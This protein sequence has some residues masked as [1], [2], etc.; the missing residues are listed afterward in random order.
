MAHTIYENFVL[1]NKM[2]DLLTTAV[3]MNAYMTADT[4][5]TENAGMKKKV[6]TYTATGNVQE[7]GM[8]EG[9]TEDIEVSFIT[10]EYEVGTTQGRT[11][12]YDEQEMTDPY[13]IDVALKGLADIMTND[14]TAKAIAEFK[15]ATMVQYGATWIFD[16]IVDAIA[17]MNLEK[18]EGLFLLINP[19]QQAAFRKNLKDDL[20]YVEGF[21]R[22]GYIG[23]VC[24]V[25]VIIS[26]AV[27]VGEAY[28]ATREA[29]TCFIKK[30]NEIEQERDANT[31]KNT[32][33]ARKVML[34][35]L[36]NA[37]KVVRLSAKADPT[38]GYTA[39]NT[40]PEAWST[41]FTTYYE[42]DTSTDT[43]KHLSG[44]VA[45]TFVAGKYFSKN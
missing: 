12:Y 32:I 44:S 9:N 35:T 31:R 41:T 13:A 28:L 33:F 24:G 16:N 40:A 17:K 21:V 2:E 38:T 37:T 27:P 15:K 19:A 4:S 25:P 26:K 23:T 29:I 36:T 3:D 8:G 39:L 43:M 1:E 10:N 22:A 45:P 6:N 11:Y 5:L 34:V 20:K 14:L 7:L 30:G 42:L 18:E